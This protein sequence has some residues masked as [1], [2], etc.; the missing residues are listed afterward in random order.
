MFIAK[1]FGFPSVSPFMGG[2]FP[3]RYWPPKGL[4]ASGALATFFILPQIGGSVAFTRLFPILAKLVSCFT[5]KFAVGNSA[6][7]CKPPSK[8]G[9]S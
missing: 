3:L 4:Q 8:D 9:G 6:T 7:C 2:N 5:C 1:L